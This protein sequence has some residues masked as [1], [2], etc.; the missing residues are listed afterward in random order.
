MKIKKSK[1]HGFI[2]FAVV[3]ALCLSL[4]GCTVESENGSEFYTETVTVEIFTEVEEDADTVALKEKVDSVKQ[5]EENTVKVPDTSTDT[6]VLSQTKVHL[7][8][9]YLAQNPELPTGC[10]ITAL[11][12]VLNYYGFDISKTEMASDYLEKSNAPANFWN[13][14]I[15]NPAS[16]SGFGCYAQPI[17]DA[18]NKFFEEK[19]ADFKAY[20]QSGVTFES[21]LKETELGRPVIIWG[22]MGMKTPYYTY[23]WKIDGETVQWIAPEHCLVLIGYDLETGAAIMSDPQ[24]GIVGYPLDIVKK[25]YIALHSQCVVIAK[26]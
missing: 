21:L 24:K 17:T 8:V 20:N 18:A 6:S 5:T 23:E 13:C 7:P 15:G 10:E 4:I 19:N 22:T 11:T 3:I 12:T 26:N 16:F 25:R 9:E 14:F 1:I 2:S